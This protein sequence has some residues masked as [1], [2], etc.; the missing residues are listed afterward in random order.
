MANDTNTS[1]AQYQ[2]Y[3]RAHSTCEHLG[4]FVGATHD[5]FGT[6]LGDTR[7][8]YICHQDVPISDL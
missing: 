4:L 8:C 6:D 3:V 7:Y 1:E 5:L 2:A